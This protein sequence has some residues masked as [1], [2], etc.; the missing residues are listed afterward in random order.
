MRRDVPTGA[1]VL[2]LTVLTD[3]NWPTKQSNGSAFRGCD[4]RM[5]LKVPALEAEEGHLGPLAAQADDG[6]EV[7]GVAELNDIA[8]RRFRRRARMRVIKADHFEPALPRRA[9]GLEMILGVHE[10]A[11][12][13]LFRDVASADRFD[14]LISPAEQQPAAF[15]GRRLSRMRDDD[16]QPGHNASIAIAMPMPPPIQSDATP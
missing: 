13:R 6:V 2:L 10:K 9:P 16:A 5:A 11:R 14:D 4:E 7:S 8:R 3:A 1:V 15:V 12:R